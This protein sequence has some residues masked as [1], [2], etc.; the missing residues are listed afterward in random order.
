MV[1]AR[2]ILSLIADSCCQL[3]GLPEE[4][5]KNHQI[6]RGSKSCQISPTDLKMQNMIFQS[7]LFKKKNHFLSMSKK[8]MFYR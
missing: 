6:Q 4:K 3:I 2:Q 1:E 5:I 8:T 7:F